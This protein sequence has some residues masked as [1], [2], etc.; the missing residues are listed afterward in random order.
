MVPPMSEVTQDSTQSNPLSG[1][2]LSDDA[3]NRVAL[4]ELWRERAVGLVFL[5][6]YLCVQCRVG[7][8]ELERDRR[9]LGPHPRVWLVG[10]GT[11][12]QAQAFRQQTAVTFPILLSPDLRAYEAMNVPRGSFRQIFGIAAQRVARRR[13]K[14]IGLEREADGGNRP[15]RRPEQDWHQLGGWFAFAPGGRVVWSHRARHAG[16]HPDHR[17]FGDAL[18]QAS[19]GNHLDSTPT[20]TTSAAGR[21]ED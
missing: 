5:R 11:P 2:V 9:L 20:P 17:A 7:A 15:K 21:E 18:Q 10:M 14:G 1:F 16:D 6:H 4:D 19:L 3:G 12:A 8:M 13:T